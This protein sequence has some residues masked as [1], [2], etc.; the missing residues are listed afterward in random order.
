MFGGLELV[1]K[2]GADHAEA[3]KIEENVLINWRLSG[4]MFPMKRQVQIATELPVRGL[5]RL[6]GAAL[7]SFDDKEENFADLLARIEKA[8]GLVAGID[9]AAVDKDP[10]ADITVPM[11]PQEMTFTRANYF[12]NFILPNLYFHTTATYLN[13]RNMGVDVG[14][15]DFLNVPG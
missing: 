1:L 2:K 13:L 4:D 3:K 11:G 8:R 15:R 7:P 10:E 9:V 6:A 14:K 12:L 5:S